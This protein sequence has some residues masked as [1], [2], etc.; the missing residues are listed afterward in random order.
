[1]SGQPIRHH[2]AALVFAVLLPVLTFS[3]GVVW[4]LAETSGDHLREH[5]EESAHNTVASLDV[6][7]AG[8]IAT[9]QST[10]NN[11]AL[12]DGD[13]STF[14][15]VAV[16]AAAAVDGNISLRGGHSRQIVNS[17]VPFGEA[18][19]SQASF[20]DEHVEV[21]RTAARSYRAFTGI[22]SASIGVPLLSCPQASGASRGISIPSL[23]R[24]N[25]YGPPSSRSRGLLQ[26]SLLAS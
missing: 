26:A 13:I 5:A 18:L 10:A 1:M 17:G 9:A 25:V 16:T 21:A 11:P 6:I 22:S 19:P 8:L 20:A 23:S 2:L 15:R 24:S 3:G 4:H 7:L 12:N 14:H